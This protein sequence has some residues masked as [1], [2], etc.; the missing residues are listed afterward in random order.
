MAEQ[1]RRSTD[2]GQQDEINKLIQQEQDPKNRAFLLVLQQIH[3]SLIANTETVNDVAEKLDKHLTAYEQH[4]AAEDARL[5]QGR[6]LWRI[7]AWLLGVLQVLVIAAM[8]AAYHE[9][10]V[11]H[12][13][14]A[15]DQVMDLELVRKICAEEHK[16]RK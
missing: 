7:L 14:M 5:N 10:Q 16:E 6:G 1:K 3:Y 8:G 4:A 9:V 13:H 15:K 11:F 2:N 12:D